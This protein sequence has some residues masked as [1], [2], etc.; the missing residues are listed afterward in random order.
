MICKIGNAGNELKLAAI[1]IDLLK[2]KLLEKNLCG[3]QNAWLP[4]KYKVNFK[5]QYNDNNLEE[6]EKVPAQVTPEQYV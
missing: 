1:N 3:K 2:I 4:E 5:L 6:Y